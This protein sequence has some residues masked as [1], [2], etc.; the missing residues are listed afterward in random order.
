VRWRAYH[1]CS[2]IAVALAVA[3]SAGC[4]LSSQPDPPGD[5][6]VASATNSFGDVVVAGSAGAVP[7]E[8]GVRADDEEDGAWAGGHASA[9]GSFVLVIPAAPGHRL[10]VTYTVWR[11]DEWVVSR[12][13]EL[14][15]DRYDPQL[16]PAADAD[17]VSPYAPGSR[18]AAGGFGSSL[19]VDPP[20]DGAARVWCPDDCVQLGVRVVVADQDT[21][22]VAESVHVAGP[23][24]LRV[25]A[26]VGDVLLVFAVLADQPAQTS[27]AV[28][29]VV[30]AP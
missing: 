19:V 23:F 26:S 15:V 20:V 25:Q 21:G 18:E 8:A 22:A 9:D 6:V 11:D 30:P 16:V 12:P 14:V 28:R 2:S 3:G 13:R 27:S 17:N 29:L 10:A 24:E 1:P 5:N 4:L 7:S